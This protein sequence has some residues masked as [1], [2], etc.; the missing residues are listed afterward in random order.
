MSAVY[1]FHRLRRALGNFSLLQH[2]HCDGH[3]ASMHQSGTH[4]LKFMLASALARHYGV[5]G[6]KYNH[7]N[8]LIGGP[9]DLPQYPHLPRLLSAH[10]IPHPLLAL[11]ATHALWGLPRYCVLVRDIRAS[12]VS[13]Y[14]K[15]RLRY[16]CPFGEFLRGDPAGRR[17]NSDLWWCF[18]FLS[19]WD[20][21]RRAA[22][23]RVLVLRYEDL[24]RDASACLSALAGHFELPLTSDDI[25]AGV[26]AGSK[27]AMAA[28]EDPA[29]PKGAVNPGA[30]PVDD[31]FGPE[32]RRWFSARC[33]RYL[34]STWG[35]DYARW[36]P[37]RG[38]AASS[39]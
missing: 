38:E 15:W 27:D 29:R 26:A 39:A 13:N 4:W 10:S 1:H 2:R 22:P 30:R 16:D 23:E 21:V 33:A 24:S 5:P 37:A 11:R 28:R 8:D 6:P 7:A 18:R 34:A 17:Y 25:A 9:H 35:Y 20:A 12:L 31:Y 36:S 3:I 19:A 32:D 14:E